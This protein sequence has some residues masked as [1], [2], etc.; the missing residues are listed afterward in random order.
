M[1]N[2]NRPFKG[3]DANKDR[4]VATGGSLF[5]AFENQRNMR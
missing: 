3:D 5:N 4:L 2:K 1:T